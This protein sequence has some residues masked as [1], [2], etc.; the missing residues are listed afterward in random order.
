RTGGTGG[1]AS[2]SPPAGPRGRRLPPATAASAPLRW[3]KLA[4]EVVA[5]LRRMILVGELPPGSR[6]SQ[7]ELARLLGVSTMPV[8]EALLRLAAEGFVEASPNRSFTIVRTTQT[9]VRDIYWMHAMLAG[10]LASR[11]C[12]RADIELPRTLRKI[13]SQ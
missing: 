11:A 13:H 10:E 12:A 8:R 5:T 3:R 4:D 2:V 9:D 1:I 7:D 6:S